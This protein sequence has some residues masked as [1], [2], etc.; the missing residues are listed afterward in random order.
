M[1]GRAEAGLPGCGWEEH[2]RG[3]TGLLSDETFWDETA[4][5]AAEVCE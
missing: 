3:G 5:V 2:P 1:E 4:A